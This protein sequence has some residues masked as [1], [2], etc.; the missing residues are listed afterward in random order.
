M[1]TIQEL[2]NVVDRLKAVAAEIRESGD[3]ILDP[4]FWLDSTGNGKTAK[5][6]YRKRWFDSDG[7]KHSE[8]ID[9]ETHAEL[10]DAI[11]RGIELKQVEQQI[12]ELQG[13]LSK[14]FEKLAALGI[15]PSTIE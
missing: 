10:R 12:S 6:Y 11:A 1:H 8:S 14:I 5:T 9:R 15:E 3:Y 4:D 7:K 2:K 13:K